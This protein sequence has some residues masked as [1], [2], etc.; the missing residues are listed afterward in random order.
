M[1]T[2]TQA[3]FAAAV[4]FMLPLRIAHAYHDGFTGWKI[5]TKITDNQVIVKHTKGETSHGDPK[6][7]FEWN[8]IYTISKE[9]Q[10]VEGLQINIFNIEFLNYPSNLQQDFYSFVDRIN[11]QANI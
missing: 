5:E 2:Y 10:D 8:L 3:L 4:E 7:N 9:S 6:F 11:A 1:K